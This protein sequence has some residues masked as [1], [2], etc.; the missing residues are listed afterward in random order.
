MPKKQW[1]DARARQLIDE[2][3]DDVAVADAVGATEGAIRSW[4]GRNRI[5][6]KCSARKP[7]TVIEHRT[8]EEKTMNEPKEETVAEQA[9]SQG[10]KADKGKLRPTLVPVSLIR[11]VA[12]VR[13]YGCYKYHDPENWK[14]V[15]PQRYRD[16]LYR[17]WLAYLADPGGVDEESGLPHLWHLACNAAFL[18][19]MEESREKESFVGQDR[20][21]A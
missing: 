4:R 13:E 5:K 17:H 15:G 20:G 21:Q 8:P 11:A 16:A 1:D 6:L 19:E 3:M 2:G 7:K 14:R 12:T 10:A 18:I 9:D